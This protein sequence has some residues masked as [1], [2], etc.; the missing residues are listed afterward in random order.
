MRQTDRQ[1]NNIQTDRQRGELTQ[2]LGDE[3][4]LSVSE[5]RQTDRQRG[6]LTQ[7]LG[8]QDSLTV[9]EVRQTDREGS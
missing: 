2:Y 3:D 1:T 6:E 8:D 5:V 9:S 4:S 7:Y